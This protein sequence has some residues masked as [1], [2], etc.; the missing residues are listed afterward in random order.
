M[1]MKLGAAVLGLALST[2]LMAAER[3][4]QEKQ[5]ELIG[6]GSGIV[7]GTAIAGPLGGMVAGIFG[8]LIAD[9]IN[10]ENQ[11]KT[12]KAELHKREQQL[13]LVKNDM[14]QQLARAQQQS[15]MQ[16]V[17]M[18]KEIELVSQDLQSNVQFRTGSYVIEEHYKAQLDLVAQSLRSNPK[19]QL[20]LAGFADRRGDSSFNQALSEQRVISVKRYLLNQGVENAQLVTT[21]HGESAPV[22][23]AQNMESDFFD[24]RVMLQLSEAA[25]VMTAANSPANN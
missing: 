7:I 3:Q 19:L 4:P 20:S 12:T 23:T 14:Q 8:L 5:K 11:L 1:K 22:D 13:V 25:A 9:D 17:S 2:N 10:D 24:R 6:L 18:D 21:S 15:Q 16:L